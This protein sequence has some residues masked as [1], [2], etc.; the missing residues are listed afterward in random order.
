MGPNWNEYGIGME[1]LSCA[2]GS[3]GSGVSLMPQARRILAV[4]WG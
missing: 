1:N 3:A 2:G 4:N